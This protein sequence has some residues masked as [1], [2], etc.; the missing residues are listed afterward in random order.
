[1]RL[2]SRQREHPVELRQKIPAAGGS[3]PEASGVGTTE[4]RRDA[5]RD[6]SPRSHSARVLPWERRY[7]SLVALGDVT[8][9]G[10]AV[11]GGTVISAPSDPWRTV[12]F[13][14][15]TAAALLVALVPAW[16]HRILGQ[17]AEE[18]HR[19]GRA[20]LTAAVLLAFGAVAA[21]VG[22]LRGWIFAVLPS[23]A[24][25]CLLQ[26]Y[27]LRKL[28]HRKRAAGR[29]MLPVIA[30][31]DPE[32]LRDLIART[33]R[34]SHLGWQI[35]AVCTTGR[36][37]SGAEVDQIDSVPVVGNLG[38][39]ARQARLDAYRAVM[40]SADGYWTRQRLQWLS[41]ELEGTATEMVVAPVLMDIAGPRVHVSEV[42]GM[43]LLRLSEPVLTGP[44]LFV[45][46]VMDRTGALFLL[47]VLSP[48]LLVIAAGIKLD[49]AGPVFYRQ[50]RVG[51]NGHVFTMLKFR[52]MVTGADASPSDGE[53]TDEGA[54][55]LFKSRCDPRVTGLGSVLRSYS[56]DELPQLVNVL[57]GDM[58]LVGPR[59]P[60]PNETE[61]YE[62][63][64]H[65]R[66]LVRPGMTGLWQVSGR[67]DLS[68]AESV[69]LDLRYVENWS[70]TLDGMILW[71][72]V[73]AVMSREGAY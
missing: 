64:M 30:A 44:R 36:A 17:G 26:R 63:E 67:S 45:K 7:R 13:A 35:R 71:K 25:L 65:R 70:L 6:G 10:L 62:P 46:S 58:S 43:P 56:L 59:P 38:D 20:L 60:L 22:Q 49:S 12:L 9:T 42:L 3:G 51:H 57:V 48:L 41:W 53:L 23:A 1:M 19:L 31:G 47:L 37:G 73:R 14:A 69:R 33:R 18:F 28:L 5:R 24:V 32:A 40:I 29:C 61:S 50:R 8:A 34:E 55:P 68:W 39:V 2:S 11:A 15:V 4:V 16:D 52:T 27:V 72:T 66:F 21:G 54:G